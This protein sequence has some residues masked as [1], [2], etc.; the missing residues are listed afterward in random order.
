RRADGDLEFLGRIDHQVKVRGFRIELGEI[1]SALARHPEIKEA[2]VVAREERPQEKRLVAYIVWQSEAQEGTLTG[3]R[4]ASLRELLR[5]SLPDYM[6]PAAFVALSALP[7]TPNGK[8]DRLSLPPPEIEPTSYEA[9]RSSLEESLARIWSELLGIKRVGVLDNFFDLGGDSILAIQ[10]ISRVAQAGWRL[11]P[12]Q[13]FETPTIAALAAAAVA[14]RTLPEPAEPPHGEVPLTPIQRRFFAQ[15]LVH[16]DHFNQSLLLT[17]DASRGRPEPGLVGQALATVLSCHEMLAAR[18]EPGPEGW[19][20]VVDTSMPWAWWTQVDLGAIPEPL[21]GSAVSAA[22]GALQASL[23]LVRGRLVRAAI[24]TA[25]APWASRL[26][27]SVHHLVVDGVSWR[28]LLE[29]VETVY[30]QL[31]RGEVP[32]PPPRT[33]SFK[34]WSEAL[35]GYTRSQTAAVSYWLD[36]PAERHRL[37]LDL[38]Q[39]ANTAGSVREAVVALSEEDTRALLQAVP[40]AYRTQAVEVLLT[41]VAEA[42]AWWTGERRLSIELE[43]HGREPIAEDLDLSRTVGWFTSL[44]PVHLDLRG[45][46]A[47]GDSLRAVKEQLRRVP[48]HGLAYGA[49]RYLTAGEEAA[50][51]ARRPRPEVIFNYLGQTD[52]AV[53]PERL[54]R[55]ATETVGP[56]RDP[57]QVREHLLEVTARVA[58]GRLSTVWAYSA[59]RH[60]QE[61][62]ERLSSTYLNRLREVIAHCV[63]P[64]AGG[65][66]PADFPLAQ[67]SQATLDILASGGP[68]ED[69]YPASPVQQ[70]MIF[71]SLAAPRSGVYVEQLSLELGGLDPLA[72]ERACAGV[73]DRYA[74]LRTGFMAREEREILQVV[75]R[76]APVVER[77]DWRGLSAAEQWRALSELLHEDRQR[78]FDVAVPPLMRFILLETGA[79]TH[80]LVWSFHHALLDGWSLAILLR[81]VFSSYG[82]GGELRPETGLPR[83]RPYRDYVAWLARQDLGLARDYWRRILSGFTVPTPL[84]ID[85][86]PAPADSVPAAERYG[87]LGLQLPSAVGAALTRLARRQRVTSNTLLQ[88]AWALLL[89]RYCGSEDVVFGVVSS[90]RSIPLPGIDTM[91]GL[92]INTLPCR[93]RVDPRR[94]LGGWLA[95]LQALQAEI[96]EFEHSP[97]SEVLGESDVP[98]GVPL[99][100]SILAFENFPVSDVV[101]QQA[102]SGLRLGDADFGEQTNYPL[103]VVARP[104]AALIAKLVYDRT[105]FD[106]L[107]IGRL[108][109]HLANLLGGMHGAVDRPLWTLSLL[110]AGE[111]HQALHEWNDT[112]KDCPQVPLVHVRFALHAQRHPG[113]IAIGSPL[114]ALTYGEVEARANRLAHHLAALGVGAETLVALCTGRTLERVVAIVGVLK[115]GAAYVSLDPTYPRERLAWLLEDAGAPVVLTERR[116]A[117]VLPESRARVLYLDSDW[118]SIIGQKTHPPACRVQPENLAYV[119]YTSGSTGTPKGV[120]IPHAGLTNLVRW[121]QD[122]YRVG[123]ADRGTQIASPAFDASIWEL[124]PYLAA[125]ASVH[126]PDEEVRLSSPGMI[127]WWSE[128]GI[129]LAY[130]MTPLAAGVLEEPIPPGLALP[131]RALIIGGDRLHRRPDPGVGFQLMNHYGPAE[132][133]V[134]STVIAVP[135]QEPG[136]T[137]PALPSIGRPLD[138]TQI[139]ILDR[140][141]QEV[142]IGVVGELY[143]AG[144]GLARGYH[145]AAEL[146]AARFVPDPFAGEPGARMYRTGDLVR[147]L[148]D[149]EIDFLGRLDHQVKLRGVRV[150][151][152]EIESVLCQHPEVRE[153]AVLVA[154]DRPGSQRLVAYLAPAAGCAP[155]GEQLR[156]FLAERL[157]AG[158][159]PSLF[160]TLE[161]LPLTPNGKVDR[162]ALPAPEADREPSYAVP[163]D[164]VEEMVATAWQEV[165]KVPRVGIHDDFFALGG[166]S[167]SAVQAVLRLRGAMGVE[168]PLRLLFERPTVALLAP[169]LS[170]QLRRGMAPPPPLR[171]VPHLGGAPLSFAQQRLWVLHQMERELGRSAYIIA[172]A[173]RLRGRLEVTAFA[174]ALGELVRRHE[175]LRTTFDTRAGEPLQ[176]VGAAGRYEPAHVDLRGLPPE[177]R[178]M[179]VGEIARASASR[180]FDLAKGPLFRTLLVGLPGEH[181]LVASMHHIVSDAWSAELLTRELGILYGALV[182]HRPSPL[183]ELTIQYADFACWQ[184]QWL[185]GEML[186]AELD[187]WRQRLAGMP[188]LELTTDRMRPA[189]A[190]LR[191]AGFAFTWPESLRQRLHRLAAQQ[192]ATVFAV[193]LAGFDALLGRYSGQEDLVIGTPVANRTRAEI[194]GLIGFFVNSLVLRLDLSGNPTFG[195]LLARARQVVLEASAHQDLPFEKLVEELQPARSLSRS[196]LFQ[197]VLAL[198]NVAPS[199]LALS[200]LE[201]TAVPL[202]SGTAKFD[203]S[204]TLAEQAEGLAGYIEYS[205]DLF[206][207]VTARRLLDHLERLLAGAVAS[208][209]LRLDELP[210]LSAVERWQALHEWNDTATSW[211][212]LPLVHE[213]FAWQARLRPEATAVADWRGRRLSYGELERRANRLAQRL[214]GLGVGPETLVALCTGRTLE[215]VMGVVATLKAGGAYVSLDPGHPR[216]R[217]ALVLADA[218][219]AVV[220][221]EQSYVAAL[222]AGEAPVICLD[223]DDELA[224]VE[225]PVAAP[226]VEVTAE[227][228]AYVVYTSGSTGKPKGVEIP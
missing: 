33:S 181:L 146:T 130:L 144:V 88:G 185:S 124:W 155:Q 43:S 59:N 198:Q 137:A 167:L 92:F 39:G 20:Q 180:L 55:P 149:G 12:R 97:L 14:A 52:Q 70:G 175:V 213:R 15:E 147:F 62:V 37:P 154:E 41:G 176:F 56:Q 71:H 200:G 3:P 102:R 118:E 85:R 173:V 132:Y 113:A 179:T 123:P 150:E 112:A 217:L 140:A 11:T 35:I 81:E 201:V 224:G 2:A 125:G 206:E 117:A 5:E 153:A 195:E 47:P 211:P 42:I 158:M 30:R 188:V 86:P 73:V 44:Y 91:V 10:I 182:E 192:S 16:Q 225:G 77:R 221:T 68:I 98:R 4:A 148:V 145:H 177:R 216:E 64:G 199:P 90:G 107:S 165:L 105:R 190:T 214:R 67:V 104:G 49:V 53:A 24:F 159:V 210:L 202:G 63:A 157:P 38:R 121:H 50:E 160:V 207:A 74:I 119:V 161:A 29:E 27:L 227:N 66:T 139:H 72:F 8:V 21:R 46:G 87:H 116:F 222:P 208:P 141:Q 28:I 109:G 166:H 95:G 218:G 115:A 84:P 164:A 183:P 184:R 93:I 65:V 129:T 13:V 122:L 187:H 108:L 78:G 126:V 96:R 36:G 18:F 204:V 34:R 60:R 131:V 99:F 106:A 226:A 25:A 114:G 75:R 156:G 209:G 142:P 186:A 196:P 83:A 138:N 54:F 103:N 163:R 58:G 100:E 128:A 223:G 40:H 212:R 26:F 228:L 194:E 127:R 79:D 174:A 45:V 135:P 189:V 170:E 143:V 169:A 151:L 133:T 111:R 193:L 32:S 110:S 7:Q 191:G 76:V 215:R 1:E 51:L 172:M 101:R 61:T 178:E 205:T 57:R 197:V 22:A 9:P 162:R 89:S 80:R 136:S 171:A 94:K 69:L 134:T 152:G 120:E 220:L 31:A 48:E 82:S 17:L 6:V 23:D 219:V 19:R 203:L 168:V